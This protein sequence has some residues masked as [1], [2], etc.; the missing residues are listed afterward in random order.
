MG[1]SK[2]KDIAKD[3]ESGKQ[4]AD[5]LINKQV[6]NSTFSEFLSYL[7]LTQ[8]KYR[9]FIISLERNVQCL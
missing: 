5:A 9:Y 6:N 2:F 8:I 4:A 7:L 1:A 3:D